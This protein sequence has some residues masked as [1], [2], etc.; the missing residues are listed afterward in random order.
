MK[1]NDPA[2]APPS[3]S[4]TSQQ[5]MIYQMMSSFMEKFEERLQK[6]ENAVSQMMN[7]KAE[8]DAKKGGLPSNVVINPQN[9]HS[10]HLR[11]GRKY[12]DAYELR[13]KRSKH[14]YLLRLSRV[15]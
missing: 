9:I 11:S 6:Q 2:H 4:S 14:N 7:N 13:W 15:N 1:N 8:Q 10:M 3:S 12:G 5:D